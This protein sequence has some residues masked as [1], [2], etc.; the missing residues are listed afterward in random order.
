[1]DISIIRTWNGR[2][3]RQREDGYLSGTDMC[4]ACGKEFNEW[5]RLSSTVT[6]LQAFSNSG[7]SPELEPVQTEAGRH[8]GSWVHRRVSLRLAQWLSP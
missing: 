3:I 4:Q 5:Y 6:Y 1:M 8:G 7:K 2:A